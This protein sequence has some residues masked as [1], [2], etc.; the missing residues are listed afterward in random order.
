MAETPTYQMT[1][2][3]PANYWM[4]SYAIYIQLN[5]AGDYNYIHA[6]CSSG[7]VIMCHVD[8][9]NELGYDSG[10]NYRRWQLTASPT[11]FHDNVARYVYIAIP[12]SA[13]ADAMAVVVFPSE[14]IDIYGK[15]AKGE[16]IGSTDCYYIFT[17]G[18]ISDSYSDGG[19]HARTWTQEIDTG[20][21][22]SDEALASGGEGKWWD[23]NSSADTVKFLKA[24]SE[25]IIN[26]LTSAW[27]S[28]KQLV[29]NGHLINGVS[30]SST[31]VDSDDTLVTPKYG[32]E[33]WLSK[34]HDDATKYKLGMGEAEVSD[35][36]KS[37]DYTHTGFPFGKGWAAMKNDGSGASMLEVDKLFVR[38]KAYF[39][40]LEIRKISYV[41]GNYVFSS[42][43]GTIYYVEWLDA[44]D[45]VIEKTEENEYLIAKFR[46]Y[47]YTDDGTTKTMNWFKEDDQVR[48]QN[49]GMAE[50]AKAANGV[51][52]EADHTTHYWW[53]RVSGVGSGVIAAKGDNKNYE[54]VDF[55]NKKGDYGAG[56][57]YPE[58]GDVMVQFGNWT[59][60]ERQGVIMIVVTGDDAPA[61]IEWQ[62]VGANNQHFTIPAKA[63]TRISPRGEG[64][65]FRG[66]FISVSGTTTDNTGKSLDEQ[67]NALVDQLNDIKNQA[68]K[69]FDIWFN[70][71][72]PHPNS[73]EDKTTNAPASDW[74][75][76]AEKGLHA[77]DLYYD[78][79]KDPASQGGRAWRWMAHNTDGNVAYYWDKVTDADTIAALD[80]AR[81][82][83]N[84]VNDI[85]SDGIISHGSEKSQL[86]IEWN[87]AL[88]NYQK[89]SALAETYA[90]TAQTEWYT[91]H[92][93]FFNLAV[94]LNGG[95]S[96]TDDNVESGT[97]PSWLSDDLG[98]DTAVNA[99]TYRS[100]WKAYNDAFAALLKSLS[101]KTKGLVDAA[102]ESADKKVQTFVSDS[103]N[104]PTPP[105][106]N[107]DF[108][109][110]TDKNNNVLICIIGKDAGESYS[111]EDWTDLSDL[112]SSTDVRTILATL[113]DKVYALVWDDYLGKSA[114]RYVDVYIGSQPS[115][116][117]YD[118]D[119]SYYN[120]V[121]YKRNS[122]WQEVNGSGFESTFATVLSILG[123]IKIRVSNYTNIASP[124]QYDL[125]LTQISI[126][127]PVDGNETM[128][129]CEIEM[130]NEDG[131]W[132][133]LRTCTLAIL[134]NYGDHIVSVVKGIQGD[135]SEISGNY[136]TQDT[137]NAFSQKFTYDAEGNIINTKKSGLLTTADGNL[138][139]AMS[140]GNTINMLMGTTTGVGWTKEV[141][142]DASY[143]SFNEAARQFDLVNYYP[144]FRSGY[145]G[146]S[147]STLK[148]PIVRIE[149]NKKYIISFCMTTNSKVSF[150]I[151]I[152]F[153]T[154][155]ECSSGARYFTWNNNVEPDDKS[156]KQEGVIY[157]S[158]SDSSRYFVVIETNTSSYEYM[159]VLFKN[160]VSS[161]ETSTD[162]QRDYV[163]YDSAWP[164]S[165]TSNQI[166]S[167]D[168]TISEDDTKKI[169]VVI[170]DV[171]TGSS[172]R[173]ARET[174]TTTESVLP[175]SV[176]VSK[177][178]MEPAVRD[179]IADIEPSEYKESQNAIESYIKQTAD[180]IT[181]Y[182]DK[183]TINANHKL[184]IN[185]DYFVVNTTNFKLNEDGSLSLTGTVTATSGSIGGWKIDGDNLC[186]GNS[187]AA[188]NIDQDGYDFA[189]FGNT[190]DNAFLSVRMDN[191]ASKSGN[192]VYAARFSTYGGAGTALSLLANSS[193]YALESF[194]S[195]N[196]LSRN[197]E[198]TMINHLAL[199]LA[200]NSAS[201]DDGDKQLHFG[202]GGMVIKEESFSPS[203]IITNRS[204][205]N[206][207]LPANPQ[208]GDLRIV[209]QGSS[210]KVIITDPGGHWFQHGDETSRQSVNSDTN[211]QW[212]FFLYD[213]FYW[214]VVYCN[215]RPW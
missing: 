189:H 80:K 86:L 169:T 30:S 163:Y 207:T 28:I 215:G 98:K 104:P 92:A 55:L 26:K 72:E 127:D 196:I 190:G 173:Y 103:D 113:A 90:L 144:A 203:I 145:S 35:I 31:P 1:E 201:F 142:S 114:N 10:H 67:I 188:I 97:T 195:V 63:Y 81:D 16:Q 161:Y 182:A 136:V 106:K 128:G 172:T 46:C 214:Q 12:K 130:Y 131:A 155:S 211:G 156:N 202:R 40:E 181:L 84:Q 213:G 146:A 101:D 148:S 74:T 27:A 205:T 171:Y 134:K 64:N 210:D 191:K 47:L 37:T 44:N 93:N 66:K 186:C 77:Q 183:I 52:T 158:K 159:Q 25:A 50:T 3:R 143:F 149:K 59:T 184:S 208:K 8:G 212:T 99:S 19:S 21:L 194:G 45:K 109:I 129:T 167:S 108:W 162:T 111:S 200:N 110:Q 135:V 132:E 160:A 39:A 88:A 15:N 71:G 20:T 100:T 85:A 61:I 123:T 49:F 174:A 42:A 11:V 7:S 170:S 58:E 187:G 179:T 105:Y 168:A 180:S 153:G 2:A 112:V 147:Y 140:Q 68:D 151:E 60:A 137:F 75:T 175:I 117:V 76:D 192:W 9:I 6:N 185:G 36:A 32:E 48:C 118:Y 91:Y 204:Y 29:L 17:Q 120:G 165:S 87:K 82:V 125:A 121:L 83:Q 38:M 164:Y 154:A 102:Q 89:Y 206:I 126:K 198:S 199:K 18:I 209:V 5:A 54:Y 176:S 95:Q 41:G 157:R 56:S 69:K 166:I 62:N 65:I 22:A 96:Y 24:V 14:K 107:G 34:T 178:Q 78:T 138:L 124:K 53:R 94:M 193:G 141:T 43:G 51:I 79:D 152:R 57:D 119:L 197:G 133:V 177:I 4:S 122:S 23:Y 115:S 70:G 150:S 13:A 33:K 73:A 139:Y 116:S